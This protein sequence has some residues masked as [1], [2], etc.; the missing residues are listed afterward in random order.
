MRLLALLLLLAA[1]LPATAFAQAPAATP[2]PLPPLAPGQVRDCPDC[3]LLVTLPAGEFHVEPLLPIDMAVAMY[4]RLAALPGLE[5]EPWEDQT[6]ALLDRL[7]SHE[8]DAA[9]LATEEDAPDLASR[10]LFAEPFLVA[11]PPDH[12]LAAREAVGD[13]LGRGAHRRAPG[14]HQRLAGGL[15]EA[16]AERR[17]D[18]LLVAAHL[19]GGQ[20]DRHHGRPC[21]SA[22]R[23][24][25]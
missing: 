12:R 7:R 24:Q 5:V 16:G 19:R 22:Q 23:H 3:P 25:Q 13:R 10:P 17:A 15:L 8:L 20:G 14:R 11:L 9:L 4:L 21:R 2:V 18:L 6:S 1:G